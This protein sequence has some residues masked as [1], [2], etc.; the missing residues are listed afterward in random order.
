MD[1]LTPIVSLLAILLVIGVVRL[2]FRNDATLSGPDEARDF[3]EAM[4]SGFTGGDVALCANDGGALVASDK[5]DAI[6]L[7]KR[8]GHRYAARRLALPAS[9]ASDG[10]F[11]LI[12]D[13]GERRFGKVELCFPNRATRDQWCAR[14]SL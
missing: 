13:S 1:W 12:V 7:L 8:I 3:A 6:V 5:G 14:L 10:E 11:R 9:A 4:T 2:L